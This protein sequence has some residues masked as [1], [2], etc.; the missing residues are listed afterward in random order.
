MRQNQLDI[1]KS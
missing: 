1:L